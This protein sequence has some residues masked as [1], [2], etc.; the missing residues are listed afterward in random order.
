MAVLSLPFKNEQSLQTV[1]R[2]LDCN[3]S[4]SRVELL[5]LLLC[6]NVED[7]SLRSRRCLNHHLDAEHLHPDFHPF[8]SLKKLTITWVR[9]LS[10]REECSDHDLQDI[11]LLLS[12]PSVNEISFFGL[13]QADHKYLDISPQWPPDIVAL[14]QYDDRVRCHGEG[15]ELPHI[16]QPN[17]TFNPFELSSLTLRNCVLPDAWVTILASFPALKNLEYTIRVLSPYVGGRKV[18]PLGE[19]LCKLSGTLE[20]VILDMQIPAGSHFINTRLDGLGESRGFRLGSLKVLERLTKLTLP[21][22]FMLG[23]EAS[24]VPWAADTQFSNRSLADQ[25]PPNLKAL[26]IRHCEFEPKLLRNA[27]EDLLKDMP[28]R[29]DLRELRSLELQAY[30]F[31]GYLPDA[32]ESISGSCQELGLSLA[33]DKIFSSKAAFQETGPAS[34]T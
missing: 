1:R 23:R 33:F 2:W 4:F 31:A 5:I 8:N 21:W 22:H 18:K 27:L 19:A 14:A 15:V 6:R 11:W 17:N 16:L 10:N 29:R 12:A 32:Y 34:T 9:S 26:T 13:E 7:V 30:H 20:T 24:T 25:L 28:A 3:E